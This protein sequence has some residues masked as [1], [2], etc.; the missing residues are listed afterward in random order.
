M[1][2]YNMGHYGLSRSVR[3][4][5]TNDFWRLTRLE[6]ALPWETALYV[7]KILAI[8]Q[9][10]L[11][12]QSQIPAAVMIPGLCSPGILCLLAML[13]GPTTRFGSST[14]PDTGTRSTS[15]A[16]PYP[17]PVSHTAGAV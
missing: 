12:W 6:A 17:R 11:R 8:A 9:N 16:T 4:Y 2:A 5:N 10:I 13:P 7:P 1:A 3:R 15:P 14:V